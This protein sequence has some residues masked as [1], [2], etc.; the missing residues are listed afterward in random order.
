MSKVLIQSLVVPYLTNGPW[1]CDFSH[2]HGPSRTPSDRNEIL[3]KDRLDIEEIYA[4]KSLECSIH[5]L[6]NGESFKIDSPCQ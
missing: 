2:L 4:A 6:K 5:G 3:Q 1:T